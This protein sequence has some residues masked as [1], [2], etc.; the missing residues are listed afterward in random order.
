VPF[1]FRAV[2]GKLVSWLP[3]AW[4]FRKSIKLGP[5]KLNLSKSG[6]GYSI[7]G[8]GFRVGKD[9][10][11][12]SYTATS[13]PGTGIYQRK[14]ASP[15]KATAGDAAPVSVDSARQTSGAGCLVL[16]VLVV[17]AALAVH[18]L[19][20]KPTPAPV[21]PPAVVSAPVAPPPVSHPRH[22][23]KAKKRRS[24]PAQAIPTSPA[25]QPAADSPQ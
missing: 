17:L 1:I 13:I 2:S 23:H 12:R 24:Q 4:R 15:D 7:G 3:M 9:A 19:L 5:L 25:N 16:L 20:S 6:V 8:C 22:A 21:T 11:G 14:Y 10:K 18:S